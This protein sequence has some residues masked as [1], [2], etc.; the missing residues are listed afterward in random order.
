MMLMVRTHTEIHVYIHIQREREGERE[1]EKEKEAQNKPSMIL[2]YT[3]SMPY[4]SCIGNMRRNVG[5]C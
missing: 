2:R 4:C 3:C 5:S 1:R